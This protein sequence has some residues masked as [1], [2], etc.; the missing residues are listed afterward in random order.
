MGRHHIGGTI[1][2]GEREEWAGV[3]LLESAL[4]TSAIQFT[5]ALLVHLAS[6]FWIINN[7]SLVQGGMMESS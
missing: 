4:S 2:I 6:P 1:V 5:N 3:A 7:Q